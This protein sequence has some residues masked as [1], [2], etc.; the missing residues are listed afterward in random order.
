VR[1]LDGGSSPSGS[2]GAGS[3]DEVERV[4]W[5]CVVDTDQGS[6]RVLLVLEGVRLQHPFVIARIAKPF[7]RIQPDPD[8]RTKRGKASVASEGTGS[9]ECYRL[10][11]I[12]GKEPLTYEWG[13][14]ISAA[15]PL[16]RRD[17]EQ[18]AI[19]QLT[20]DASTIRPDGDFTAAIRA[21]R[22]VEV[23]F[24]CG[25][26]VLQLAFSKKSFRV[27]R[28]GALSLDWPARGEMPRIVDH[29]SLVPDP[30]PQG[31]RLQFTH[32]FAKPSVG[33]RYA[34]Y[35]EPA[36]NGLESADGEQ[37][38]ADHLLFECRTALSDQ[39]SQ[40][41]RALSLAMLETLKALYGAEAD[42]K[43]L[44]L[45]GQIWNFR[46]RRLRT[47]FGR[48]PMDQWGA[49][50]SYGCGIAGHAFRTGSNLAYFHREKDKKALIFQPTLEG[51]A[52]NLEPPPWI[53]CIPIWP[54]PEHGQ[55]PIGVL[56]ISSRERDGIVSRALRDIASGHTDSPDRSETPR[57][58]PIEELS[59][60]LNLAFWKTFAQHDQ[61]LAIHEHVAECLESWLDARPRRERELLP[62]S[63]PRARAG[64]SRSRRNEPG[65]PDSR[66]RL[67][68]GVGA[69]ARRMPGRWWHWLALAAVFASVA[70]GAGFALGPDGQRVVSEIIHTALPAEAGRPPE[71]RPEP[72]V[73]PPA[74][75]VA[76]PLVTVAVISSVTSILVALIQLLG[77]RKRAE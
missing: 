55:A 30:E 28:A 60:E 29:I 2:G 23:L 34:L 22:P 33:T 41:G 11:P 20:N 61:E 18:M 15:F 43:G 13:F 56:S 69:L 74:S 36:D 71:P 42:E 67:A 14:T 58:A 62:P 59:A 65:G 68:L 19:G 31:D 4:T 45:L 8:A 12:G 9:E 63:E 39:G 21:C 49:H 51:G 44:N 10:F 38:L 24:P 47:C 6:A 70:L 57:K 26:I 1:S 50:F 76:S 40:L 16:N 77:Q 48:Y 72:S 64:G 3:G 54:S 66:G 35:C 25:E 53:I 75:P 37:R 32:C 7:C 5:Q 17:V 27:R 46:E 73:A 52:S